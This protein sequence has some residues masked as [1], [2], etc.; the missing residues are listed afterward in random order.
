M[1]NEP[2]LVY[3]VNAVT[4]KDCRIF[5]ISHGN[6]VQCAECLFIQPKFVNKHTIKDKK[7]RITHIGFSIEDE[8][9]ADNCKQKIK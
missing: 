5:I 7:G 1:N 8:V 4:T 3:K 6:E 2:S 9:H